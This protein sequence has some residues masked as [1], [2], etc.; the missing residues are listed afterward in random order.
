VEVNDH[1]FRSR[2]ARQRSLRFIVLGTDPIP[3]I[4][5]FDRATIGPAS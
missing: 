5:I 1:H 2:G 4:R 3:P